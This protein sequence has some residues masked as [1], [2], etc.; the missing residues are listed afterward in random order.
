MEQLLLRL[1][2]LQH[3]AEGNSPPLFI[4]ILLSSGSSFWFDLMVIAMETY[5]PFVHTLP[6][7]TL[8]GLLV[9]LHPMIQLRIAA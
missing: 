1:D 5:S 6:P 2:S 4:V 7:T 9:C 8:E 3:R